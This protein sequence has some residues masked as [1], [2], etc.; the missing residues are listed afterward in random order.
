MLSTVMSA[1]VEGRYSSAALGVGE[2]AIE[3]YGTALSLVHWHVEDSGGKRQAREG[4]R[5]RES[6]REQ[7]SE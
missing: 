1:A 2:G 4:E 3:L 7:G 6:E 5:V